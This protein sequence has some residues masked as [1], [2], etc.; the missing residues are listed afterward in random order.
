MTWVELTDGRR[1]NLA[2]VAKIG[3]PRGT[4]HSVA[5][6]ADGAYEWPFMGRF[7]NLEDAVAEIKEHHAGGTLTRILSSLCSEL[8]W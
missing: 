3:R 1:L 8:R 5:F 7:D 6:A 2:Y 4:K